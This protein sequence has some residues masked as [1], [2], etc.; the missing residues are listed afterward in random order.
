MKELVSPSIPSI[1]PIPILHTVYIYIFVCF[2]IF[3]C[4]YQYIYIYIYIYI[5]TQMY[6]YVYTPLIPIAAPLG[7]SSSGAQPCT[8]ASEARNTKTKIC[9][10]EGNHGFSYE[11]CVFYVGFMF[12]SGFK[13]RYAHDIPIIFLYINLPGRNPAP[14]RV[15]IGIP[16]KYCK[17]LVYKGINHLTTPVQDFAT[18]HSITFYGH[19]KVGNYHQT[20]NFPRD[21][22]SIWV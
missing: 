3:K 14:G 7:A 15:A 21:L 9:E 4:I 19:Q 18:I 22:G 16:M 1:P 13:C 17:S 6:V 5:C 12:F 20:S 8:G 10:A 2:S 11:I